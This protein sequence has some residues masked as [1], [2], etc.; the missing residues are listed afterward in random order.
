MKC[1]ACGTE[2]LDE[3]EPLL[4]FAQIRCRCGVRRAPRILAAKLPPSTKPAR[5][6]NGYM[7]AGVFYGVCKS[8][9]CGKEFQSSHPRQTCNADACRNWAK[10]RN[11]EM[12][13]RVCGCGAQYVTRAAHQSSF[14]S[15]RCRQAH[16]RK[17]DAE[18]RPV[19]RLIKR[20]HTL[21]IYTCSTCAKTG[22]TRVDLPRIVCKPCYLA[23]WKRDRL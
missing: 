7:K 22:Q 15:Q 17:L 16:N 18:R 4:G 3:R 14:C 8:T 11:E 19:G 10:T 21:Q 12:I 13:A 6:G 23:A 2:E 20:P 5:A 9:S 1:Q